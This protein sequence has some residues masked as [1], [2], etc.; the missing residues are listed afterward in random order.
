VVR[1][2]EH[3][4]H[5][6]GPDAP[7]VPLTVGGADL[8]ADVKPILYGASA[9]SDAARWHVVLSHGLLMADLR[10][11]APL[12]VDLAAGTAT[13]ESARGCCRRPRCSPVTPSD[14]TDRD[15]GWLPRHWP[16]IPAPANG[17][18]S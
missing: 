9:V 2:L 10:Y 6:A 3:V 17:R 13:W 12:A 11:A 16:T 4:L 18:E 8:L 5:V 15:A 1:D 14:I 7:V